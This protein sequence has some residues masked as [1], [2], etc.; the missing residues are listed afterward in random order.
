MF[1]KDRFIEHCIKAAAE[2]QDAMREVMA[3]AVSDAAGVMDEL[4]TCSIAT[5]ST[6]CSIRLAR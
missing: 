2:G 5:S 1:E 6:R 3:E 4:G